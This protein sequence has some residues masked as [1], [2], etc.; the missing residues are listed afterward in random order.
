M[1]T[2]IYIAIK[3]NLYHAELDRSFWRGVEGRNWATM[4]LSSLSVACVLPYALPLL[5]STL[6]YFVY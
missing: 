4:V 5:R 3:R 6:V 2:G 1:D